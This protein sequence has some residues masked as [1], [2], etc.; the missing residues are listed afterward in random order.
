MTESEKPERCGAEVL[1]LRARLRESQGNCHHYQ[2][3]CERL[4]KE[5]DELTRVREKYEAGRMFVWIGVLC[6]AVAL[7]I[8]PGQIRDSGW[9]NWTMRVIGAALLAMFY[10]V[11]VLLPCYGHD[12]ATGEQRTAT[13]RVTQRVRL[14]ASFRSVA[15]WG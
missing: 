1:D 13:L 3:A 7:F 11:A 6:L 9:D 14:P 5:R 12:D 10:S 2:G 15:S 4:D 8:L